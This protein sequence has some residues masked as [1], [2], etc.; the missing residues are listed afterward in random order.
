MD[1]HFLQLF[2]IKKVLRSVH[3]I[4]IAASRERLGLHR[5]RTENQPFQRDADDPDPRARAVAKRGLQGLGL[6]E[7]VITQLGR[8]NR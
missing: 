6:G 5:S 1:G 8:A 4:W 3:L 2:A 7:R